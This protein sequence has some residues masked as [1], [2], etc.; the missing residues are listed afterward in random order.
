MERFLVIA[1][2]TVGLALPAW[3][4]DFNAGLAAYDRGDYAAALEEWKPLAEQGYADAQNNLGRM[5]IN[6]EGVLQDDAEAVRWYRRAAEQGYAIAQN[7]LGGMYYYGRGVPQDYV[8]AHLW[9]SLAATQGN[10]DAQN[11]RGFVANLIRLWYSL[12][13]TQGGTEAQNS[14]DIVAKRMT[15]EQIAEAQRL[16]REWQ[17][18]AE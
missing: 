11:S 17:P 3:G 10:T 7:N 1:A 5:Y 13:A 15:R 9:F 18:K 6:S 12:V 4:Q 8:Q 14:R 16:A 2:L